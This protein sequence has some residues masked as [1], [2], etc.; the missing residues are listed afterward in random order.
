MP[1]KD[2]LPLYGC[3]TGIVL[4]GER[5]RLGTGITLRRGYFDLFDAP[6]MAFKAPPPNAAHP[7]PWVAVRGG[8]TYQSRAELAIED[9]SS[10]DG[11]SPSQV[12]WLTATLLRLRI[13]APVRVAAVANV[14]LIQLADTPKAAALAFEAAPFQTGL[15]RSMHKQVSEE[16]L[17]WVAETLPVAARLYHDDRFMRALSVFDESIWSARVEMSTILIWTAIEILFE[18]GSQQ[19]KTKAICSALAEYVATDSQ[20]RDRAYNKIRELYEKR[21]RVVHVG[22]DI[23]PQD[24]GQSFAFARAAFTNVLNWGELPIRPTRTDLH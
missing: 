10:F 23:D 12:A 11:F 15:F 22:R 17:R 14:P 21:G 20:D 4:P 13:E 7:A 3:V 5:F 16:D 8:F 2:A 1:D 18:L 6:M 19:H 24:F 9:L